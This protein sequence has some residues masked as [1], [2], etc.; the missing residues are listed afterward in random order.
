MYIGLIC[1]Y[2]KK[3][4]AKFFFF[5]ISYNFFFFFGSVYNFF[6][7]LKKKRGSPWPV[8]GNIEPI[9]NET[10][11]SNK[12]RDRRNDEDDDTYNEQNHPDDD[13]KHL[14]FITRKDSIGSSSS[15][16]G[17]SPS[18]NG[19]INHRDMVS[20]IVAS[21]VSSTVSSPVNTVG[22]NERVNSRRSSLHNHARRHSRNS[23][24]PPN[25]DQG[26][27]WT[28][29]DYESEPD[30]SSVAVT[31]SRG[32]NVGKGDAATITTAM[33]AL[34]KHGD[35]KP[36]A[37]K[38]SNKKT[39]DTQPF[40]HDPK[41][42]PPPPSLPPSLSESNTHKKQKHPV[43]SVSN[44]ATRS[45]QYETGYEHRNGENKGNEY[46]NA[47]ANISININTN[48]NTN[49]NANINTNT[50]ANTN[51]ANVNATNT[52]SN[53]NGN[54]H[55]G[56]NPS[57][58][59]N[60]NV[61]TKTKV[62]KKRTVHNE[63]ENKSNSQNAKRIASKKKKKHKESGSYKERHETNKMPPRDN[64]RSFVVSRQDHRKES[65]TAQILERFVCVCVSY[66]ITSQQE[67]FFFSNAYNRQFSGLSQTEKVTFYRIQAK[68][69]HG[70]SM[71]DLMLKFGI[72][73]PFYTEERE[74]TEEYRVV[75][76]D[77]DEFQK[78][79]MVLYFLFFFFFLKKKKTKI[80][81]M[82]Q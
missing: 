23:S 34:H 60:A 39:R 45:S 46:I 69:S 19:H 17:K 35:H 70:I 66:W 73:Q 20:S 79:E 10:S 3:A 72:N 56:M 51:N 26:W 48:V 52:T 63:K 33:T 37:K 28:Y 2:Q 36:H 11:K 57:D 53:T 32:T 67:F 16:E 68:K 49:I 59:T 31:A 27:V 30:L 55:T 78:A 80:N 71:N 50:S 81:Y 43:T 25:D 4:Q 75:V 44:T 64:R 47:N 38:N 42:N 1:V 41:D 54:M 6:F 82:S 12:R 77:F 14:P 24:P 22:S 65:E 15:D 76:A 7:F 21:Q 13:D 74:N 58:Y 40:E 29:S 9:V 8:S 61:R 5:L 18:L 62:T